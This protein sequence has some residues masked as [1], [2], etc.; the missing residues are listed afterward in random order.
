[1]RLCSLLLFTFMLSSFAFS[2]RMTTIKGT[3]KDSLTDERLPFVTVQFDNTTI[4]VFS[5][6]DGEFKLSNNSNKTYVTV[7]FLGYKSKKIAI[8]V[9]KTTDIHILLQ[10]ESQSLQEIVVKPKK[11]KYSKK[12]NPAVELIRKVI[13]HKKENNITSRDQYQCKEYER[14]FFALNDFKPDQAQFKRYKFIPNYVDTSIIDNKAILPVSVR[15]R[16]SASYYRKDPKI[17]RKIVGAYH[18]Q[19]IDQAIDTEGVDAIIAETFKDVSIFD[20]EIT[21]LFHDF[22]GPLSE[23]R[24]IGFYKW[25]INDTIDV[26]GTQCIHMSFAPFNARDVGFTGNLFVVNDSTYAVKRAILKT[27]KKMNINFVDELVIH[28][29]FQKKDSNQWVPQEYKMAI[30]LTMFEAV[31]FYV[32]KTQTFEDF[33]FDVL[34]DSVYQLSDPIMYEKNYLKQSREYWVENRPQSHQKD[35]KMDEMIQDMRKIFLFRALLDAGNIISTGSIPLNKD[36]DINKLDIGT[37]PTF[38]SYNSIEGNRFRLTLS[39]TNNFHPNLS[40]YGYGAYGTRDGVMKYYGEATWSFKKN[41]KHKDEFPKNNL[42]VA[43]KYDLNNLGQRFTQAERDNI[44]MSLKSSNNEKLTYNRQ[45]Q[46]KYDREYHNGFSFNILTQVF[47]E[48]PAGSLLFEKMSDLGI[49]Y[50]IKDL[51]STELT[52]GVRY[53]P[54]EKF[55]QQ[56]RKRYPIPSQKT[57]LSLTNTKAFN[58]VFGG[59]FD[60]DK[61]SFVAYREQW[62]PPFGKLMINLRAEKIWGETPFP[63]LLTPSANNSFTI[64]KG[65]FNMINP[66]EFAHDSQVSLEVYYHMGGWFFNRVPFIKVLKLRE[67]FGIRGFYGELSNTNNPEK[68]SNQLLFPQN[69]YTTNKAPY[70]EYNIGIENIFKLFR[71]DY[72]RRLNYLDHPDISKDGFRISFDLTF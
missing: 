66:L 27:P 47:D 31:K 46:I 67:V 55:F 14:I 24:S 33:E 64:Q 29:E 34:A 57:V 28:H 40:L 39:T 50:R 43:Y 41:K 70:M 2:Q 6:T 30:D 8:P 7:S 71:I 5:D 48:R 60:Y 68:N 22:V 18:I 4:G 53:S 21:L 59:Q 3:I 32:D 20:D 9:G 63:L 26:D 13:A 36:P 61:L 51:R 54:D 52:L 25:Y 44:L 16:V 10:P 49:K 69:T 56:R 37:L 12:D 1:M 15:E 62:I 72:V 19:G 23:H 65:N 45:V 38:Y 11:E 58:D 35:Y 17:E 42:T